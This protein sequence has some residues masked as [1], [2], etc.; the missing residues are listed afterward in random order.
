MG[1][2]LSPVQQA[3]MEVASK[4]YV[5]PTEAVEAAYDGS[6]LWLG[7]RMAHARSTASRALARLVRRGLLWHDKERFRCSW[8]RHPMGWNVYRVVGWAGP[9]QLEF[10]VQMRNSDSLRES[11]LP[12]PAALAALNANKR[13]LEKA[14]GQS[15]S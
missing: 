14:I 4:G 13:A 7:L 3:I 5:L 6:A 2:G 1:R 12:R 15:A 11:E 9:M 8:T 10:S